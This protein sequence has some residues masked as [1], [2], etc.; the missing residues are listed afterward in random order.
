VNSLS[1]EATEVQVA[2]VGDQ[3]ENV[4]LFLG[5]K[6]RDNLGADY[7]K[8]K[9]EYFHSLHKVHGWSFRQE[10]KTDCRAE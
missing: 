6:G 10:I 3:P 1:T 7:Q 9:R 2:V 5:N 4:G 8:D